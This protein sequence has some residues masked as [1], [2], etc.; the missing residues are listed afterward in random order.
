MKRKYRLDSK[1]II[2]N[3]ISKFKYIELTKINWEYCYKYF[4]KDN[5][6]IL[7]K[8]KLQRNIEIIKLSNLG[9]SSVWIGRLY[10]LNPETVRRIIKRG[11]RVFNR[12][13]YNLPEN[14]LDRLLN[15]EY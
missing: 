7:D 4:Y 9:V 11:I 13:I 1:S 2:P 3:S 6:Y 8:D 15:N 10:K 14:K 5:H 12:R